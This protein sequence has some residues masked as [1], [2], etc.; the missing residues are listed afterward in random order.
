MPDCLLQVRILLEGEQPTRS[1]FSMV[2]FGLGTN[3]EFLA[4]LHVALHDFG[5]APWTMTSQFPR[6][7]SPPKVT[8]TSLYCSPPKPKFSPNA[9]ISFSAAYSKNELYFTSLSSF[10]IHLPCLK[11]IFIRLT[12]GHNLG[13]FRA[14]NFYFPPV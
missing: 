1:G 3:A 13:A 8:S 7:C 5:A 9:D 11:A 12:S 14:V 2:S 4:E 10:L 6:Q